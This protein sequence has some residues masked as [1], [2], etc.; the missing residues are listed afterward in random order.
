MWVA[1][2]AGAK[3]VAL[4]HHDPMHDDDMLD[5][6]AAR[7]AELRCGVDVIVAREGLTLRLG[8]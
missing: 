7:C 1:K 6:V 4:Y 5:A 8:A 2:A 3:A